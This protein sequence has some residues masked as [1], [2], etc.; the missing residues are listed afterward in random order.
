MNVDQLLMDFEV[1]FM[2]IALILVLGGGPS[3]GRYDSYWGARLWYNPGAFRNGFKG[4]CAVFVTAAF[5]FAGTER[6][7]YH[8]NLSSQKT[9]QC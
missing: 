5:S 3:G 9:F 8:T 1:V 6:E 2:I 4:F 7:Y